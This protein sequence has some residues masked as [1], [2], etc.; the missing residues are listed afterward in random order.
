MPEPG[1]TAQPRSPHAVKA[2]HL[3]TNNATH[4]LHMGRHG[5]PTLLQ[6]HS[7]SP[8]ARLAGHHTKPVGYNVI[9][10]ATRSSCLEAA[11]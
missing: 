2:Y 10:S 3:P 8:H 9:Y 7:I 5:L 4:V 1:G 6:H 11:Q